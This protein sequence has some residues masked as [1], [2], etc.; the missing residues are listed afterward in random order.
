MLHHWVLGSS[1]TFLL[2]MMRP[3]HLKILG[4]KQ[5][6]MQ[7]H[8]PVEMTP[9]SY[10][11]KNLQTQTNTKKK[12]QCRSTLD[13]QSQF[14]AN[15][16]GVRLPPPPKKSQFGRL[17]FYTNVGFRTTMAIITG[18]QSPSYLH[19]LSTHNGILTHLQIRHKI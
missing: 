5:L 12:S 15:Y 18:H 11:C 4:T 3:L 17:T 13:H 1:W 10:C 14:C 9:H 8:I 19:L 6:V 7:H 16:R 2:L